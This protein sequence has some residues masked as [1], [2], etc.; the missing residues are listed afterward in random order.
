MPALRRPGA[1]GSSA[2]EP[3]AYP[4]C[5]DLCLLACLRSVTD[6]CGV[7]QLSQTH[8][9]LCPEGAQLADTPRN[10]LSLSVS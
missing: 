9:L 6:S 5:S 3:W 1:G 4:L 2:L 8:W 7:E 10:S